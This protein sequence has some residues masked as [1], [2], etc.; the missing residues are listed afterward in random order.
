MKKHTKH[1]PYKKLM[2]GAFR[3]TQPDGTR[4]W[5]VGGRAFDSLRDAW[6]YF[7]PEKQKQRAYLAQNPNA[8]P[9]P[10]ESE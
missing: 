6:N 1:L 7:D 10:D 9:M 2:P 5:V 3:H 4:V 8:K